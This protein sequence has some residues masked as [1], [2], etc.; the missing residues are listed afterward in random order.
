M[1]RGTQNRL[2]GHTLPNE[3]KIWNG[4]RLASS[5]EGRATCSCGEES[6]TELKNAERRRIWHRRHKDDVREKARMTLP[7]EVAMTIPPNSLTEIAPGITIAAGADW[8]AAG[9]QVRVQLNEGRIR[10]LIEGRVP[11]VSMQYLNS[12]S[13][14]RHLGFQPDTSAFKPEKPV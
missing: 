7:M 2:A 8:P 6:P 11:M 1:G 3:G 9:I 14:F 10:D 4:I 5:F 13:A 12:T